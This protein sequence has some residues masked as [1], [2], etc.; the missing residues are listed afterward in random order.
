M[1]RKSGFLTFCFACLPG[2]G[3]MYLGYMKRGL[4]VM[5]AFWGLIFV[6]SLLNM[7]ILGILAPIIWAYS[8]FDTFNL[9]AQTPE[10]VAANPDAYLFDVESI[11]GS[12][13]KNVV[14]RRHNLFGGLLIFLG[15]YILYNTFLRPLLWDL[16]RTYGL[17]WL[18]NIMDGIPTLVIAVLIILLGLYLVKGPSRHEDASGDDY[19]AFKGGRK[20]WLRTR[21]GSPPCRRL[22]IHRRSRRLWIPRPLKCR[23]TSRRARCAGWARS[24]WALR[25]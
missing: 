7:G 6:A 13:W 20:Q 19:T 2:A 22:R 23:C 18:G 21:T 3:E 1:Q 5:I 9:R 10:Q 8:F 11:A 17:V 25:W 24:P 14:A 4:S 15:A 16:Y 12:N